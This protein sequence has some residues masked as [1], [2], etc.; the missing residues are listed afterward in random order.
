MAVYCLPRYFVMLIRKIAVST[1]ANHPPIKW[2]VGGN[3]GRNRV[4]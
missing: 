4:I 1:E 2:L 3:G